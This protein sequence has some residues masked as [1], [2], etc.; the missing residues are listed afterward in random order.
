MGRA[1]DAQMLGSI[2]LFCKT[3]ELQSFT[4]AAAQT[5]VSQAAVSR[6]VSRLESRLGVRLFVR[7]TR[8][9]RLS[10]QG[11]AY[12]EQCRLALGLLGDAE[13]QVR[14]L[15]AEAAGLV[16][17]SLPTTYGHYRV[18]PALASFR[19]AFPNIR[20]DIQLTNQ[21]TDL[22]ADGYDLAIRARHLP[23]S[24]MIVRKLDDAE[25]VIVGS[26][27]Y[28]AQRSVPVS[29]EDLAGHDCIQ[30]EHPR[31]GQPVP[32][33]LRAGEQDIEVATFGAL[34][35]TGDIL[36]LATAARGG[37]GLTQ[38]YRFIVEDDLNNQRLQ[39]VMTT[40]GSTSRPFNL[41]Y[42]AHRHMPYAVRVLVDYLLATLRKT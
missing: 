34:C 3:A 23:D 41:L 11:R 10:E 18:L 15:Q 22:V 28:L 40:F 38:I 14:G 7:S 33:L 30:F 21:N 29:V 36:G 1:F 31:T 9:V 13:R 4:A 25:L 2:E 17:I 16:R 24:G 26:P 35:I 19:A 37:L 5:G 39:E 27:G 20:L 8:S 6:S 42:P 32:W 12:Y